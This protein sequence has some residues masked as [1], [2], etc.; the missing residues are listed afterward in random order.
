MLI[1]EILLDLSLDAS[2]KSGRF[3]ETLAKK[4]NEFVPNRMDSIV[5]FNLSLVL[6]PTEIDLIL[7][8]QGCKKDILGP[9]STGHVKMVPYTVDKIE[10]TIVQIGLPGLKGSILE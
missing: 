9:Q 1:L 2:Y 3:L 10:V 7:E 4:S 8:E 6:L 5:I